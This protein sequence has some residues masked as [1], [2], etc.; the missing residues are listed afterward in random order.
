MSTEEL[1]NSFS[2]NRFHLERILSNI[3]NEEE[4][5]RNPEIAAAYNWALKHGLIRILIQYQTTNTGIELL[6]LMYVRS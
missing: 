1:F 6:E 2:G 3:P 4:I 5:N